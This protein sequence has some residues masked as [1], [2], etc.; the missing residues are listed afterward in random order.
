MER[1]KAHQLQIVWECIPSPISM[2]QEVR[3]RLTDLLAELLSDYWEGCRGKNTNL[4]RGD[5]RDK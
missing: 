4:H 3:N 1:P 2:P 5:E